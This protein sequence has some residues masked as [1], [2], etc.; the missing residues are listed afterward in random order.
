MLRRRATRVT[1]ENQ[2][3]ALRSGKSSYK[4]I[5][6]KKSGQLTVDS[7]VSVLNGN[8]TLARVGQPNPFAAATN[9]LAARGLGNND[10]IQVEGNNDSV[11]NVPV[12]DITAASPLGAVAAAGTAAKVKKGTQKSAQK[13]TKKAA[14]KSGGKQGGAKAKSSGGRA[15]SKRTAKKQASKKSRKGSR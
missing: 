6:M 4:E 7:G 3:R 5:H 9:F 12:F 10:L 8:T 2:A 13:S 11:G 15:S 14:R 1:S